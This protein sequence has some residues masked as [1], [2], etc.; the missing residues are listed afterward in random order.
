MPCFPFS[1]QLGTLLLT[2]IVAVTY[3]I[4]G[5]SGCSQ[6]AICFLP[7]QLDHISTFLLPNKENVGCLVLSCSVKP[8]FLGHRALSHLT[9]TALPEERGLLC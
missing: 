1:R 2:D 8:R 7:G 6:M 3:L 9:F 5:P 4:C